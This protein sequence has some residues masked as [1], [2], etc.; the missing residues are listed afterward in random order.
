MKHENN[1]NEQT[2]ELDRASS[3]SPESRFVDL[4]TI[5]EF[6]VQGHL[7]NIQELHEREGVWLGMAKSQ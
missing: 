5:A 7:G 1:G 4:G 2:G 3:H 6:S